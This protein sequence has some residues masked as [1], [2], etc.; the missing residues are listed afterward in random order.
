MVLT[1][2]CRPQ[3]STTT[4]VTG[5]HSANRLCN[6]K[7]RIPTVAT[8]MP[9]GV[10]PQDISKDNNI[11]SLDSLGNKQQKRFIKCQKHRDCI[12]EITTTSHYT[13]CRSITVTQTESRLI[14]THEI[15]RTQYPKG[16]QQT[17]NP[18][19]VH[20]TYAYLQKLELIEV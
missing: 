20:D 3:Q 7:S 8:G 15:R 2:G 6:N 14:D 13:Y 1:M 5:L 10:K 9:K 11:R 12:R 16:A 19:P 18:R 4:L 17:Q